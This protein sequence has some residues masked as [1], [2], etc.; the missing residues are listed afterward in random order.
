[1]LTKNKESM[2]PLY[3]ISG[4]CNGPWYPV[5]FMFGNPLWYKNIILEKKTVI[6]VKKN[7]KSL[8]K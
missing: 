8:I 1:M 3:F 6:T 5:V 4:S 7:C 2:L